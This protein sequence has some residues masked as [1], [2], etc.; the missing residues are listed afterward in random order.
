MSAW[1]L[2]PLVPRLQISGGVIAGWLKPSEAGLQCLKTELSC[3]GWSPCTSWHGSSL[4]CL[5]LARVQVTLQNGPCCNYTEDTLLH[6]YLESSWGTSELYFSAIHRSCYVL[7]LHVRCT[8]VRC[9]RA[10]SWHRCTLEI[11][12]TI[13]TWTDDITLVHPY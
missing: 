5:C 10:V 9:I 4:H 3:V 6:F 2:L 13:Q 8:C 7:L 11:V 1:I 12:G